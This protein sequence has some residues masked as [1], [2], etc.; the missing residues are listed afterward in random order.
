MTN[1]VTVKVNDTIKVN[2]QAACCVLITVL[3]ALHLLFHL[4]FTALGNK[5]SYLSFTDR[6][7]EARRGE[8]SCSR[9]H[10]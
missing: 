10:C 2:I 6:E 7:T 5:N 1:K 3:S 8:V 9:S 4:T